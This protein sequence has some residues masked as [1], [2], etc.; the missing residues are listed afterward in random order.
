MDGM[1]SCR[2][3]GII[4]PLASPQESSDIPR[5]S[6]KYKSI[7]HFDSTIEINNLK[8]NEDWK[9]FVAFSEYL[10]FICLCLQQF[11]IQRRKRIARFKSHVSSLCQYVRSIHFM[12][13]LK[14]K[15]LKLGIHWVVLKFRSKMNWWF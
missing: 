9:K 1:G 14:K 7:L 4:F 8:K 2:D 12:Q 15:C 3:A 13:F 10:N 5:R 11:K 6:N